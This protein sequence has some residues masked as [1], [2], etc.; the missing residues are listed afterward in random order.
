MSGERQVGN[1]RYRVYQVTG[2]VLGAFF[3]AVGLAAL[4]AGGGP[5]IG[6]IAIAGGL[7]VVAVSIVM[8][9]RS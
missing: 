1:G 8:M 4:F 9:V 5:I 3:L 6:A 7:T 2:I